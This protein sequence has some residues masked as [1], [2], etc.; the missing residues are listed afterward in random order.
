VRATLNWVDLSAQNP[1]SLSRALLDSADRRAFP[2]NVNQRTGKDVRQAQAGVSWDTPLGTGGRGEVALYGL[3]RRVDNPIPSDII[4][5]DRAAGGARVLGELPAQLAGRRIA[6]GLGFELDLQR[7]DRKNYANTAGERGALRL[8]QLEHVRA[9]AAFT[10]LR[11]ELFRN[12]E[13]SAGL[14]YDRFRFAVEDRF[15]N[16][17]DP[18]DSGRRTM[19]AVSPSIGVTVQPLKPVELFASVSASF[20]TPSTTELANR[21]E[22]AGGFN[23]ELEPQRGT[24]FEAGVRGRLRSAGSLEFTAHHTLLR[25]ELVPFEVA[26]VTGRT[27]FRNAGRSRHRG[28]EIALAT[29]LHNTFSARIAY[30]YLDA[31]FRTYRRGTA[32]FDGNRIPGMAPHTL[33]VVTRVR[34][35]DWFTEMRGFHRDGVPVDDANSTEALPYFV[36]DWRVGS[37][38]ERV[39]GIEFAPLAGVNNVFDRTYVAA[40]TVNAFGGRFFEPGPGRSLYVGLRA[41]L[42][43]K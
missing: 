4:D 6:A 22:G 9:I 38:G 33:D 36:L 31:R 16:D 7:D 34:H 1:G 11:L 14:R 3:L 23:P 8:D 32:V 40:V 37:N 35:A 20:E 15:V 17:D 18:D 26:D 29:S 28:F 2:G 24:T 39:R 41:A 21:P 30:S 43:R 13:A 27:F 12:A 42:S 10:H 5:L 25:D 19:D